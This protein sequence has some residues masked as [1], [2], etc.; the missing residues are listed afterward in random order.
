MAVYYVDWAVG[1]DTNAGT[2]EGA[3]N[4]WKHIGHALSAMSAGDTIWVKA[5]AE[6]EEIPRITVAGNT[7]PN[8]NQLIGYESV[9]G[10]NGYATIQASGFNGIG[11]SINTGGLG[12]TL[13]SAYFRVMN[14]K[15]VN[16]PGFGLTGTTSTRAM[17]WVN[18][19]ISGSQNVAINTTNGWDVH[20]WANVV[21][22]D[23]GAYYSAFP[24]SSTMDAG[25]V[26]FTTTNDLKACNIVN[27]HSWHTTLLGPIRGHVYSTVSA[28]AKGGNGSFDNGATHISVNPYARVPLIKATID[29]RPESGGTSPAVAG[30]LG[31]NFGN[32]Q[33][34]PTNGM[35]IDCS[36][37]YFNTG[38]SANIG[39]SS[40]GYYLP[41]WTMYNNNVFGCDYEINYVLNTG[42]TDPLFY[43]CMSTAHTIGH[44]VDPDFT[45]WPRVDPTDP[46]CTP[47]TNSGLLNAG[48]DLS[49]ITSGFT[50]NASG[51]GSQIG[52]INS[53]TGTSGGGGVV[54]KTIYLQ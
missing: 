17:Q 32:S 12:V 28:D 26:A 10:D 33:N 21:M 20:T 31:V 11:L 48:N 16:S 51:S 5:S 6:Y 49:L 41:R 47:A 36:V 30:F 37:S 52:G 40:A 15:I 43:T 53:T 2:S 23:N 8:I 7:A 35:A 13:A 38:F 22:Y 54:R 1:D 4:A 42:N 45:G 29:G 18:I 25:G 50:W 46:G 24:G 39:G 3:G 9:T 27:W 44:R 14:F 34:N 19:Y